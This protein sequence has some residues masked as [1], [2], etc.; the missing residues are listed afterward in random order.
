MVYSLESSDC[1]C[2]LIIISSPFEVSSIWC[3]QHHLKLRFESLVNDS[4]TKCFLYVAILNTYVSEKPTY[5]LS[6]TILLLRNH[7]FL[8]TIGWSNVPATMLYVVVKSVTI[9]YFLMNIKFMGV[10][11]FVRLVFSPCSIIHDL[12]L[13]LQQHSKNTLVNFGYKEV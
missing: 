13:M 7:N 6:I 9:Y 5:L 4:T 11:K 3:C 1:P 8:K 12:L 10:E 2:W